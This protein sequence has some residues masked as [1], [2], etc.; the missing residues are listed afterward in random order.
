MKPSEKPGKHKFFWKGGWWALDGTLRMQLDSLIYNLPKDWDFVILITGDRMVRVGKSVLAM[1]VCAYLAYAMT[2]K[3]VDGK[4]MNPDAYTINDIYFDNKEM[5][6]A[7]FQKPKYSINQYD[8]GREGLAASKA[9]K[10]FQQDLIDF[11]TECGQLNHIFVIVA[12][13]FFELKEEIAI[14]RSECLINVFRSVKEEKTQ[15]YKGEEKV[16]VT[17]FVR[18][19]FEFFSRKRKAQLYDKFRTTRRKNYQM[20]KSNF[21]GNFTNQYPLSEEEY[22]KKKHDSLTRFKERHKEEN[23]EGINTKKRRLMISRLLTILHRDNTDEEIGK[24][25]GCS[26]DSIN[27]LRNY[28]LKQNKVVP[29]ETNHTELEQIPKENDK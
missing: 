17:K 10:G 22:K 3:M 14:G 7:A 13:D 15:L 6:D 19:R 26:K 29:F 12:P 23:K 28:E 16:M 8:E 20:V 9:M 5:M 25:L 1:T 24:I 2:K 27:K 18:G 4:P 11:F 21:Y